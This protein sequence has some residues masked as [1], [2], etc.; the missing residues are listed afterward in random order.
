MNKVI[1]ELNNSKIAFKTDLGGKELSAFRAGGKA[2]VTAYPESVKAL[3]RLKDI[4]EAFSLPL[5]PFG[6]GSNTLILDG[7]YDGTDGGRCDRLRDSG[8][9]GGRAGGKSVLSV[10]SGQSAE[11]RSFWNSCG[12]GAG[13]LLY[14]RKSDQLD[15]KTGA[16]IHGPRGGRYRCMPVCGF[17]SEILPVCGS[18][19][20]DRDQVRG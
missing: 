1:H 6:L 5:Y 14:R 9:G 7:G 18:D 11:Y 17:S 16:E 3:E 12:A 2:L 13:V 10:F 15:Q 19:L 8:H 20:Y 4:S